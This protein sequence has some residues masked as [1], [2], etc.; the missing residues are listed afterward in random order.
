MDIVSKQT[1]SRLMSAVRQRDTKPEMVVR[2]MVHGMGYRYR[3]HVAE[4]PGSP[5]LVFPRLKKV[6]FVHGC[7]WHRHRCKK[8]TTPAT[9]TEF[10]MDKFE[11][12]KKRDRKNVQRLRQMGW[13][14][15]VVWECQTKRTDWLRE[16]LST[17]LQVEKVA[18][19]G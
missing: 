10:W 8:A 6:I 18:D 11:K 5:D 14:V 7:F 17:F 13:Q 19:N 2:R 1:R 3:L 16:K 15:L 12:N 9:R 4:L